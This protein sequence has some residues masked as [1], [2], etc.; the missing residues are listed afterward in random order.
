MMGIPPIAA[1]AALPPFE[2]C[3]F[4]TSAE[5]APKI[6][7]TTPTTA[8]RPPEEVKVAAELLSILLLLL[9]LPLPPTPVVPSP[10]V[11]ESFW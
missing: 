7:H 8:E 6:A 3:L 4:T 2:S 9:L 10:P 1:A 11:A 5:T